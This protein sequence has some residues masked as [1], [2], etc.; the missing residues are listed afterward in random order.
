M[1]RWLLLASTRL[2]PLLSF[3]D[4]GM[5]LVPSAWRQLYHLTELLRCKIWVDLVILCQTSLGTFFKKDSSKSMSRP[6]CQIL[7]SLGCPGFTQAYFFYSGQPACAKGVAFGL[8][9]TGGIIWR[10]LCG[11]WI[12]FKPQCRTLK[13]L[14]LSNS[15]CCDCRVTNIISRYL[16]FF[17]FVP[18]LHHH[19]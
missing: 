5:W 4:Q 15:C 9:S 12:L 16:C 18:S 1:L 14:H 19:P 7:F 3:W 8:S 10:S 2:V 11:M 6:G 17:I 13:F